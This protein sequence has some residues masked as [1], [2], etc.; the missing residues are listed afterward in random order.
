M[1][2]SKNNL[3]ACRDYDDLDSPDEEKVC[4]DSG[5]NPECD[6]DDQRRVKLAAAKPSSIP[7][8]RGGPSATAETQQV[9]VLKSEL[10]DVA[11]R[12]SAVRTCRALSCSSTSK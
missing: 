10:R 9:Q 5:G 1:L 7:P 11:I 6:G 12:L 2:L 3:Y 4:H 8:R